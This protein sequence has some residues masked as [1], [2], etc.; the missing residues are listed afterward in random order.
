MLDIAI[1]DLYMMSFNAAST[2]IART[3]RTGAN[4]IVWLQV[5]VEVLTASPEANGF[6]NSKGFSRYIPAAYSL[7]EHSTWARLTQQWNRAHDKQQGAV[8]RELREYNRS[9]WEFHAKGIW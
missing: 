2:N 8:C 4:Y 6:F 5:H 9:G 7:L 3:R 1:C